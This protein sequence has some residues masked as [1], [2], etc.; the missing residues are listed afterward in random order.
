[1]LQRTSRVAQ[2]RSDAA[3]LGLSTATPTS[4]H[5]CDATTHESSPM[6]LAC[7]ATPFDKIVAVN[8]A[9]VGEAP[10]PGKQLYVCGSDEFPGTCN[11]GLEATAIMTSCVGNQT[12]DIDLA[13]LPKPCNEASTLQLRVRYTCLCDTLSNCTSPSV[14]L[15]AVPLHADGNIIRDANGKRFRLNGVN[16]GGSHIINAA[17]TLD[18]VPLA[19][20]TRQVRTLGFNVVRLTWSVEAV[21]TNPVVEDYAIA[22]NPQL[23][24]QRALDVME[25]VVVALQHEGVLVWLD[26]HMLDT[27]WC[28][29][30]SD[31][32]GFWFNSR[33]SENDWV[34]A[35][36]RLAKQFQGFPAVVGVGLKNE[37]RSVCGGNSWGGAGSFCNATSLDPSVQPTGCVEMTWATG[38][39]K[40][41]WARAAGRAGR[42]VLE[43]NPHWLV[44]VSGLEYSTDLRPVTAEGGVDIPA[45]NLLYEAHDYAW[46][47]FS[48]VAG[49]ILDGP[50]QG[51]E[52]GLTE[53]DAEGLCN[54][55]G[56]QCGGATCD[57]TNSNCTVRSGLVL[58]NGS[59]GQ[60]TYVKELIPEDPF[61]RYAGKLDTFW[62]YL[63]QDAVAPV[64]MSEIGWSATDA[65]DGGSDYVRK[66][67][68]YI[69]QGGPLADRGGLDWAFWQ[70]GG[71][72]VGGTGRVAGATES[73]GVLNR[74]ATG[75]ADLAQYEAIRSL[76]M[77]PSA[78]SAQ[79]A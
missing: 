49:Q 48:R 2:V 63:L 27:N 51:N 30:R 5:C 42:S 31:C 57:M 64:F 36:T 4:L 16:W 60:F 73:Y 37:P 47:A 61:P 29:D 54:S 33:W 35:W 77:D 18:R 75:V 17:S 6:L 69:Q 11:Q 14:P 26:N 19:S 20:V 23:K 39:V 41:Q 8:F 34:S 22:A 38:P 28:C 24:G 46:S 10:E 70:L 7:E 65:A 78:H 3:L 32:D 62:G 55:L 15:P 59:S 79:P 76:M 58:Q 45:T 71:V 50:I 43:V 44:S 12:C 52:T 25:A 67:S 66:V 21:L 13:N 40:Y 74:C 72:Q 9:V 68:T 53:K 1:M 56:Y